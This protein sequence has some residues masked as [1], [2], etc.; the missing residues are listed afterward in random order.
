MSPEWISSVKES[1]RFADQEWSDPI[2][3]PLTTLDA[4]IAEYGVPVFCKIDVEGYEWQVIA[5]LSQPLPLLSF[6]FVPE[7]AAAAFK[8]IELLDALGMRSFNFSEGE[9]QRFER[10][11]WRAA[12]ELAEHLGRMRAPQFGDVYARNQVTRR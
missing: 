7:Y 10:S 12:D 2:G 6:E 9:S 1:G 5:G 4:L 8:A 3:V 11:E